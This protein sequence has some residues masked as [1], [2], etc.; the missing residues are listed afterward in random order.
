M[1]QRQSWLRRGSNGARHKAAIV[2]VRA[3]LPGKNTIHRAL[4]GKRS[5]GQSASPLALRVAVNSRAF[6][7]VNATVSPAALIAKFAPGGLAMCFD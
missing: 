5:A 4:R 1:E 3:K 2:D 6:V 7:T